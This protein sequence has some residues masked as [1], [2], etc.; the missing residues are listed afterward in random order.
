MEEFIQFRKIPRLTRECTITEKIDGTNGQI[1]ILEDGVT[2]LV[3]SRNRW[4]T[5][6]NDNYG[7]AKWAKDNEQELLKLGPGRHYGEWYGKGIQRGYGL[8]GRRFVIFNVSKWQDT[9]N[10]PS[11]VG[12]VPVLATGMFDSGLI[13]TTLNNL[14]LTGSRISPGFMDVEG[15]VIHHKASNYL[16][17]K[18]VEHDEGKNERV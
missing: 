13:E 15:I 4:I 18:T 14:K 3:G 17:K 8:T 6:E 12:L 7:F 5:I 11:C 2:M 1:C 10:L 16:F 9:T